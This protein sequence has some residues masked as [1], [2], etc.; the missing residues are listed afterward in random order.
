[1]KQEADTAKNAV[2]V[3]DADASEEAAVAKEADASK[4]DVV[5][6]KQ[7]ADSDASASFIL[8]GTEVRALGRPSAL[9]LELATLREKGTRHEKRQRLGCAATIL[10]VLGSLGL[11][12][13]GHIWIAGCAGLVVFA[14]YQ[15]A[16]S[17][18]PELADDPRI[19]FAEAFLSRLAN[20]EPEGDKGADSPVRLWMELNAYDMAVADEETPV[21]GG[22][23]RAHWRQAWFRLW[24]EEALGSDASP[25]SEPDSDSGSNG[26]S[27]DGI[28][29]QDGAL[30]LTLHATHTQD[31]IK[32]LAQSLSHQG[33]WNGQQTVL[34][35][36]EVVPGI[37]DVWGLWSAG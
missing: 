27:E 36:D 12:L 1:M 32:T 30:E 14:I 19:A 37:G 34:E 17:L 8:E 6:D 35:G 31:G 11:I 5:E 24:P 23:V 25:R 3:T 2:S 10:G 9:L 13:L 22:C 4:E 15:Y 28:W 16:M 29:E 26:D 20:E 18:D 7:D 33:R 21:S